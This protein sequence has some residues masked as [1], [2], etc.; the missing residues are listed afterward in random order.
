MSTGRC[1]KCEKPLSSVRFEEIDITFNGSPAWKGVAYICPV[2]STILS[3][4][5]D[6]IAIQ[7]DVL[8]SIE[9]VRQELSR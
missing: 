9:S 8:D 2:C 5:I 3:V 1:P 6:P 4:Q 7:T